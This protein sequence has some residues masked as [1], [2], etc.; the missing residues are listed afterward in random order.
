MSNIRAKSVNY[1]IVNALVK[2]GWCKPPAS[3]LAAAEV[4]RLESWCR[5]AIYDSQVQTHNCIGTR[6]YDYD[7]Y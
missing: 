5:L 6:E 2:V 7:S 3:I 1:S 4:G